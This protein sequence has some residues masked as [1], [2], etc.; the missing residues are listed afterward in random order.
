M[1]HTHPAPSSQMAVAG[2]RCPLL[3]VS[4]VPAR[5]IGEVSLTSAL[6]GSVSV[7]LAGREGFVHAAELA[8]VGWRGP[9][10][11]RP[12]YRPATTYMIET[13]L[14]RDRPLNSIAGQEG[15]P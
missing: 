4:L 6:L 3:R 9:C 8:V 2:L 11:P 1:P 7:G 5:K 14:Y 12:C 10:Y 13:N 15:S